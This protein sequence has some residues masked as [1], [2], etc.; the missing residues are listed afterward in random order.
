MTAAG[1]KARIGVA[2]PYLAFL[3]VGI[4]ML[5]FLWF[6]SETLPLNLIPSEGQAIGGHYFLW[7]KT[8][9]GLVEVSRSFWAWSRF[10]ETSL[11]VTWPLVML[12]L[13]YLVVAQLQTKM[14]GHVSP[15]LAAERV[16]QVRSSG[17]LLASTRSA[18][19]IG[20]LW[21]S[22]GL[23]RIQVYPAGIV[24]KPLFS[25]EHAIL[26]TEISAVTPKGG[27]SERS[28]PSRFPA[29]GFAVSQ[30]PSTYMPRG[31]FVEIEHAGVGMASPLELVGSGNWGIAQA[32]GRVADAA[33]ETPTA[34]VQTQALAA[35]I[36]SSAAES[37]VAAPG[38]A[39]QPDRG[40]HF[41]APIELGL[42]ILGAII[43]V[44]LLWFGIAWI[45]PQLGLFGFVWTA[46]IVLILAL[47]VRRFLLRGRR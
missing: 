26:A 1:L 18:G 25:A 41:P 7:S 36:Q 12:A 6:M 46:G 5:N 15:I 30:V 45:I 9:G 23:V 44:A 47:N 39:A 28:V 20:S 13:A 33:R 21:L 27:L 14:G 40:Q 42:A 2:L 43:G 8:N 32:I 11:F 37:N 10:H 4:G 34:R 19:L 35:P 29:L 17:P 38:G 16:R 24:L 31:P 3:A 22:R